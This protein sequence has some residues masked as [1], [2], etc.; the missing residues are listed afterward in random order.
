M[1]EM[2]LAMPFLLVILSL[3]ILFGRDMVRVQRAGV[4]DRSRAW[5]AVGRGPGPGATPRQ[6]NR[7]FYGGNAADVDAEEE[8]R[9]PATGAEA[10]VDAA[11]AVDPQAALLAR[12]LLELLPSGRQVRVKVR[13]ANNVPFWEQFQGPIRHRHLRLEHEWRYANGWREVDGQPWRDGAHDWPWQHGDPARDSA[14][15]PAWQAWP[16]HADWHPAGP[17]ASSVAA[18]RDTFFAPFETALGELGGVPAATPLADLIR[19]LARVDAPYFGPAV[20]YE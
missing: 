18:V 3:L 19:G 12:R 20:G 1:T 6:M 8:V 11:E 7:M 4:L 5:Q 2:L 9:F 15:A 14:W 10:L 17:G 13:H 16:S